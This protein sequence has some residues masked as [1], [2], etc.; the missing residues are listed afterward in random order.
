MEAPISACHDAC[1]FAWTFVD[2]RELMGIGEGSRTIA[3]PG[4]FDHFRLSC[5]RFCAQKLI[6]DLGIETQYFWVLGNL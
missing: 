3:H 1:Q 6:L 2:G 4:G 5:L